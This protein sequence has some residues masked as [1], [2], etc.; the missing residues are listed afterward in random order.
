MALVRSYCRL[1]QLVE[2]V[3]VSPAEAGYEVSNLPEGFLASVAPESA[4]VAPRTSPGTVLVGRRPV[5]VASV[6]MGLGLT[7]AATSAVVASSVEALDSAA[8]GCVALVMMGRIAVFEPSAKE[9][10]T[11]VELTLDS[12][13]YSATTHNV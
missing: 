11:V 5:I 13:T 3:P 7:V 6:V 4:L 12:L 9:E 1:N 8:L 2:R 10:P